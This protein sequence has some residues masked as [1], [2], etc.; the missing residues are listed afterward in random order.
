MLLHTFAKNITEFTYLSIQFTD[1]ITFKPNHCKKKNLNYK[2]IITSLNTWFWEFKYTQLELSNLL[3]DLRLSGCDS[4][5]VHSSHSQVGFP[6]SSIRH[7]CHVGHWSWQ[8][9][10][11]KNK[12]QIQVQVFIISSKNWRW[13]HY[14]NKIYVNT[15]L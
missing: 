14:F 2:N 11:W 7:F 6:L 3:S 10:E 9:S 1:K 15:Y 13:K 12:W 8:T 4:S 5:A